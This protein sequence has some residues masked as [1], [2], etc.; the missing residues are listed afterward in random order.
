MPNENARSISLIP[1]AANEILQ[2]KFVAVGLSGFIDEATNA[3]DAVGISLE[4][5]PS[6]AQDAEQDDVAIPVALL[7]GAKL[8]IVAGATV[9]PG[10]RV[11]S[12]ATGRAIIATGA[13]SRVLGIA[14]SAATAADE[15]ITI[16]GQKAAGQFVA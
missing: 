9:Q 4:R 3:G 15:I 13:S 16:I 1:V 10:D 5:S 14:L 11:M 12:D 7:D 6:T 2:N 8:E